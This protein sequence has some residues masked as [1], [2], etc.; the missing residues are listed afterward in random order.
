[1]NET[2]I[3]SEQLVIGSLIVDN[4][5]FDEI[6]DLKTEV[7]SCESHRMIFNEIKTILAQGKPVDLIIVAQ[8]LQDH[9]NLD[10][11][12][13]L[14]YLGSIVESIVSTKNVRFHADR[15]INQWKL[16]Q[17][18]AL[19][20]D[21]STDA[22]ALTT[23]IQEIL[24]KAE[25]SMFSLAEGEIENG[26]VEIKEAVFEAV[27]WEDADKK[28]APTGLRDLDRMTG[29]FCPSNLIIIAGRPS[30]GK[31]QPLDSKILMSD[32]SWKIMGDIKF[33]DEIA[34]IDGMPSRVSAIHPQGKKEVYRIAMSD[35]RT[36]EACSDHLWSVRYRDWKENRVIN[37]EKLAKMLTCSRYKNRLSVDLIS[38]DFGCSEVPLDAYVLGVL[39]GDGSITRSNIKLTNPD[40][41]IIDEVEYRLGNSSR[42][43]KVVGSFA[44]SITSKDAENKIT[45]PVYRNNKIYY[46]RI[47][48][49]VKDALESMG[50][51]GLR[52]ENKFIP[53]V[54]FRA[55]K[56]IRLDLLRGLMDTDG[57]CEKSGSVRFSSA[58][59]SL[60]EG[61]RT[62][63][64]S[65]G[66]ICKIS[67]KSP[68][69]TYLNENK[70]GLPAY[71]CH[72]RHM[73]GENFFNL[74]RKRD[75]ALRKKH[76]VRLTFSSIELS[77]NV[78]AQ[79]ITVT[80]PSNLYITD[81][82]LLTHNSSLAFQIA[83]HVS[84][85]DTVAVFSLEMSKREIG[86]RMLNFHTA[87]VGRS[88]AVAHLVGLKM[89]IDD[90]PGVTVSHVRSQCRKI[91]RKHGLSMIVIDYLQL[92]QGD[93]DNRN[94]EIGSIS[95]G[96][97]SLAKEFDVPVVALSQLSRK[98]EE[99]ADKRPMMSD[100]RDS[101]EIEQDA[102]LILFIYRDEVYQP[103]T[104]FKGLAEILI[105][106]NR[107]GATGDVT[108]SFNGS[109]TRFL[110]YSGKPILRSVQTRKTQ[111]RGF[112]FNG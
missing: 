94:Q 2:F 73:K 35:G 98:V 82:Y 77:R 12:G 58:S 65:L 22:E 74:K 92:M 104:E 97:K 78:P 107:N 102:D 57:W 49:P 108:T 105:R 111:D 51:I 61:V 99:R 86:S 54:Y 26:I 9:G 72:I 31:A 95:R 15:L 68:R 45:E 67:V 88:E 13:N 36:T 66:G 87:N 1:M 14:A 38:G 79:C 96:L 110:D 7:F 27:D 56:E 90:K 37:T 6:G 109:V 69:Y 19:L 93:G 70:K 5:C 91:K 21:L 44:Y 20:S 83:E 10:R 29:G 46:Q 30:M 112:S 63:V 85:T 25:S 41:E 53:E 3:H 60:A 62:L 40:Q 4:D 28:G 17:F 103:E 75:R 24:D 48:Y 39:L 55:N 33:G 59:K 50:L 81:D 42:I 32:G 52:S 47:V 71:I 16:R 76:A 8:A 101:G 23:P 80:H 106:K 34:S 43:K 84:K 89:H 100:L 18:K 11:V 64:R